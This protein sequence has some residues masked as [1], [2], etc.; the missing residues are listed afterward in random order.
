MKNIIYASIFA[1][2]MV[3][4]VML[5][6]VASADYDPKVLPDS[7]YSGFDLGYTEPV[8]CGDLTGFRYNEGSATVYIKGY[9]VPESRCSSFTWRSLLNFTPLGKW[10][11]YRWIYLSSLVP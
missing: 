8:D 3:A 10:R 4:S 2:L 5:I 1:L 6:A 7:G 11:W 9:L